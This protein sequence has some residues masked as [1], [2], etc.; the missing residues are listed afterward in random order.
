MADDTWQ[1]EY[2]GWAEAWHRA[3]GP[4]FDR[5]TVGTRSYDTARD[6][7]TALRPKTGPMTGLNSGPMTGQACAVCRGAL[8]QAF[9]HCF[10]CG[11]DLHPAPAPAEPPQ[12]APN[13]GRA[14]AGLPALT[15]AAGATPHQGEAAGR[16][17]VRLRPGRPAGAAVRHRP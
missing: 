1:V 11:A 5:V 3:A 14:E 13:A 12:S 10:G 4:G 9:S 2:A 7:L 16:P 6:D 8:P 15:L 17:P